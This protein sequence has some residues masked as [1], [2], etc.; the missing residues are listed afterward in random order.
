MNVEKVAAQVSTVSD[1]VGDAVGVE[2]S[3]WFV[4]IVNHNSEKKISERLD[5]LGVANYVPIQSEW[6]IWKNGR[7]V[8]VDRVVI[9]NIVF[10]QCTEHQRRE[11]VRLPYIKRFM[12]DKAGGSDKNIGKPLAIIPEHQLERLKFMLGQSEL[13]V[14]FSDTLYKIGDKV[15]VIRGCLSGLEG[16]MMALKPGKTELIVNLNYLGYARVSI[17]KSNL[18]LL[19]NT[20]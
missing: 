15:R 7:K 13:P 4:A 16:E 1:G 14:S 2:K 12:T 8:K 10:I 18:E 19:K 20:H 5:K 3:Y 11:I 17:D 6:H 9:P